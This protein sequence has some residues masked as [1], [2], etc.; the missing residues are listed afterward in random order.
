MAKGIPKWEVGYLDVHL[1]LMGNKREF[2]NTLKYGR[3]FCNLEVGLL[4]GY[5]RLE[6]RK[7][8]LP[9]ILLKTLYFSCTSR[10]SYPAFPLQ[11]QE[12]YQ[13]IGYYPVY[14]RLEVEPLLYSPLHF[15]QSVPWLG[16]YFL[17]DS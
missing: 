7:R 15:G 14:P 13:L 8:G 10:Y 3:L 1:P 2:S 4:M 11:S 12:A 17:G 9:P 16:L 5:I 6:K